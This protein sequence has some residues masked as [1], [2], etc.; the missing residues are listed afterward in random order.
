MKGK[1]MKGTILNFEKTNHSGLISGHDGKRY[2]F[3]RQN[4]ATEEQAISEGMEVD[5]EPSDD[6]AREIYIIKKAV[7]NSKQKTTA[8]LL[9]FFL[10][11][12]GAH[13]FYLGNTTAGIL[14]IVFFWTLIPAI[15][16]FI[17]LIQLICMSDDKFN[18]KF[19]ATGEN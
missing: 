19:S 10:G 1:K 15:V 3:T 14:S 16:A 9:C 17:N 2:K 11:G 18:V 5:F 4:L 6:F 8:I 7:N 12:F 13:H